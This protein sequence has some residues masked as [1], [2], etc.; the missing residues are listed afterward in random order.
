MRKSCNHLRQVTSDSYGVFHIP[1][2]AVLVE[3][4]QRSAV[5]VERKTA[6]YCFGEEKDSTVV[7]WWKERQ[8]CALLVERKT[9]NKLILTVIVPHKI[10]K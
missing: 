3:R 6:L 5:L 1:H 7:F 10:I 9:E 4:K 8:L 2:C